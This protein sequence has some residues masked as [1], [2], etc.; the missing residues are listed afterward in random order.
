MKNAIKT[1]S[2]FV[3]NPKVTI[4]LNMSKA[5]IK[6]YLNKREQKKIALREFGDSSHSIKSQFE[7]KVASELA[8]RLKIDFNIENNQKDLK[9]EIRKVWNELNKKNILNFVLCFK[10]QKEVVVK[11][12]Q[13]TDFNESK[14]KSFLTQ[15]Q[16]ESCVFKSAY[17][18]VSND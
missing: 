10:G 9:A 16:I 7:L 1:K 8:K 2:D 15:G 14:A 4:K 12:K 11:V 3:T 18:E 6:D 17:I 13:F 5:F